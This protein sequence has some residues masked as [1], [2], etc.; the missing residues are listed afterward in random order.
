MAPDS[1]VSLRRFER[2][3]EDVVL[4]H[5]QQAVVVLGGLEHL[6]GTGEVVAHGLLQVDVPAV[7][8][9]LDDAFGVDGG[10]DECL[11]GVHLEPA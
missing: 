5:A 11:D 6:L 9:E 10:R 2:F 4:H 3:V 8:E 1:T 7:A